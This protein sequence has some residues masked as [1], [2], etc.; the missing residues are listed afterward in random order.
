VGIYKYNST[1]KMMANDIVPP[2]YFLHNSVSQRGQNITEYDVCM[3]AAHAVKREDVQGSQKIGNLWRVYVKTNES[4]VQLAVKG[5]D[6]FQQ[7][8]S[9][10]T[11]NPYSS[12][13]RDSRAIRVTIYD[14]KMHYSNEL[15]EKHLKALGAKLVK[16]VSNS[17]IKDNDGKDTEFIGGDRFTYAETEHTKAHPLPDYILIGDCVARIKHYGQ[18]PKPENCTKCFLSGHPPWACR[19]GVACRACKKLGHREG[20]E[21]CEHFGKNEDVRTFGGRRDPLSNFHFC[22][23]KYNG[24]DYVTREQA[25]QHQ[26]AIICNNEPVANAIMNTEDPV[27]VKSLSKCIVKNDTWKAMEEEVMGEICYQAACQNDRYN[28]ELVS[29]SGLTLIEAVRGDYIWG[30]GLSHDATL[31][32]QKDKLPGANKMGSILM[33]VRER[34]IQDIHMNSYYSQPDEEAVQYSVETHNNYEVLDQECPLENRYTK[35]EH[36]G[37][38]SQYR[39]VARGRAKRSREKSSPSSKINPQ[40]KKPKPRDMH[41]GSQFQDAEDVFAQDGEYF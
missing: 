8:V 30:S 9:L 27:Q 14:V 24:F 20:Q 19:N 17:K 6:I 4:R 34:V 32:T 1:E 13:S 23:F 36:S 12:N 35:R 33:E 22:H 29:T 37:F 15:V 31:Y 41:F 7:H 40:P 16:P 5:I 11:E 38:T 26:K 2:L 10:S 21:K 3:A 25:Y 39:S 18:K 28:E